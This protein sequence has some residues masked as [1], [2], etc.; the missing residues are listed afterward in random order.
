MFAKVCEGMA[1]QKEVP[2]GGEEHNKKSDMRSE[3]HSR[4][5]VERAEQEART[6]PELE[7]GCA[8]TLS[9]KLN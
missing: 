1:W 3:G 8:T 2:E 9:N 6:T 5:E 7:P 4:F